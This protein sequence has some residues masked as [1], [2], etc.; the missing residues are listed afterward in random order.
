MELKDSAVNDTVVVNLTSATNYVTHVVQF[1]YGG[2]HRLFVK[3]HPTNTSDAILDYTA[4]IYAIHA[5]NEFQVSA[6]SY[7]LIGTQQDIG[8]GPMNQD[9]DM[10]QGGISFHIPR[11]VSLIQLLSFFQLVPLA[12][13]PTDS[14]MTQR[15]TSWTH[16]AP[17]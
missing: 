7:M 10:N 15:F 8:F 14:R 6:K 5:K 17:T 1:P 3:A 4:T 2:P 9:V 12:F 11:S 16:S 13:C